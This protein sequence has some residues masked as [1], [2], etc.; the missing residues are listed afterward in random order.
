M[1]LFRHH[2]DSVLWHFFGRI[3]TWR[4]LHP[5]KMMVG[6]PALF[7]WDPVTFQGRT[8]KLCRGCMSGT[9]WSKESIID[10]ILCGS[11]LMH[12]MNI[13]CYII[14]IWLY[15][16]TYSYRTII[17]Y[18]IPETKSLPPE[19]KLVLTK[20]KSNFQTLIFR[21]YVS[22]CECVCIP[23]ILYTNDWCLLQVA[24]LLQNTLRHLCASL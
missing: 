3:N 2:H 1:F 7:F 6:G 12:F 15:L 13:T 10:P 16:Y 11:R 14:Y 22:F 5:W 9:I 8:V 23:C 4:F 20:G 21:G 17:S 19:N 18:I 24:S